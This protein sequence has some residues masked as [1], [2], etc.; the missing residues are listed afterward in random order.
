MFDEMLEQLRQQAIKMC[1]EAIVIIIL[2]IVVLLS[3]SV[4]FTW[5]EFKSQYSYRGIYIKPLNSSV[6]LRLVEAIQ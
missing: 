4:L 2:V 5:L 3:L 1:G 6:W